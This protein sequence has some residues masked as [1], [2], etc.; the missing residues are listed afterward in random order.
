[1]LST[2]V[3]WFAQQTSSFIWKE[4]CF[5]FKLSAINDFILSHSWR[6]QTI[7]VNYVTWNSRWLSADLGNGHTKLLKVVSNPPVDARGAFLKA[8]LKSSMMA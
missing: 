2:L 6:H 5:L 3:N 4:I 1:M 7:L 8:F